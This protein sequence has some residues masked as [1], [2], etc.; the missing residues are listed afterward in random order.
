MSEKRSAIGI[1]GGSFDPIH[2]GHLY[3]A[4]QARTAVPLD[5]VIFVPAFLPPHK[6]SR[7]LTDPAHRL[8]MIRLALTDREGMDLDEMEIERGG[9]SY[10]VDTVEALEKKY[11]LAELYFIIGSDS[12][13]ELWTWR[14]IRDI[15]EKVIFLV[16]ERDEE[17][18][19]LNHPKLGKELK[20]TPLKSIGI[21][22]PPMPVSSTLLRSRIVH[23]EPFE[24]F[25]P[26]LVAAYIRENDLYRG[27]QS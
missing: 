10:T 11:P 20:G 3:L 16:L 12:L 18:L 1:L 7:D 14:R 24:E 21:P 23:G 5:R 26:P 27:S 13:L 17:E 19:S 4:D 22:G 6:T 8:N 25:I 9:V 15:A 2:N